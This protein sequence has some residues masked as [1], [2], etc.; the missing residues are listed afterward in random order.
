MQKQVTFISLMAAISMAWAAPQPTVEAVF[1]QEKAAEQGKLYTFFL[2]SEAMGTAGPVTKKMLAAEA[3][4]IAV[5]DVKDPADIRSWNKPEVRALVKYIEGQFG[6][7]AVG[8]SSWTVPTFTARVSNTQLAALEKA[9]FFSEIRAVDPKDLGELSG[10]QWF[11][12]KA[13][14]YIEDISWGKS[15][16]GAN[17]GLTTSN[18]VYVLDTWMLPHPD[19]N[20]T[21]LG[22]VSQTD[23]NSLGKVGDNYQ[24]YH[25]THIAGILAAK[26]NGILTQGVN[27]GAPVVNIQKNINDNYTAS[28]MI[29]KDA[30]DKN[31]FAVLNFSTNSYSDST[32]FGNFNTF[33][34][35]Q[36]QTGSVQHKMLKRL[37]TRF[38]V[39]QSAGNNGGDACASAYSTPDSATSYPNF[40]SANPV[41]GIIVVGGIDSDGQMAKA[42]VNSS[43]RVPTP[44]VPLGVPM[45]DFVEGPNSPTKTPLSS[46]SG[47]CVE[48]WAPSTRIISSW[49]GTKTTEYLSGTSMAAPHVSALAARYGNAS[50]TPVEREWWIKSKLRETGYYDRKGFK[51]KVPNFTQPP[52]AAPLKK[53]AVV[54]IYS[55]GTGNPASLTDGKYLSGDFWRAGGPTGFVIFDLG[56]TKHVRAVRMTPLSSGWQPG[57]SAT[58]SIEMMRTRLQAPINV[59]TYTGMVDDLEP[60]SLIID[61]EKEASHGRFVKI[62]TT[63][64]S[65]SW[66][67]WREIEIYGY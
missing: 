30:E 45:D 53:L 36:Y 37:S 64:N 50:T 1:P 29:L 57:T 4:A 42:F 40:N 10:Q 59:A 38:L 14:N 61:G 55:S 32:E 52:L 3:P 8:M 9:P 62:N 6:V 19:L 63:F 47:T 51:I 60:I 58:H 13:D 28:D 66:T 15:A 35:T 41:D 33:N 21:S 12:T 18:P 11:D 23:R 5:A 65:V 54:K 56:S 46:A 39:A 31:L 67:A 49:L 24:P 20:F 7:S 26:K 44:D 16:I 48:A 27:P 2:K 22:P 34:K 43:V 25:A 17:D